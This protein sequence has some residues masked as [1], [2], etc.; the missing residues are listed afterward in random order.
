[1]ELW[2]QSIILGNLIATRPTIP[3]IIAC[4]IIATIIAAAFMRGSR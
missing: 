2:I 3:L 1:M 4:S